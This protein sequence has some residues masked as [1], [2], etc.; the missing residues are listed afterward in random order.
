MSAQGDGVA[1]RPTRPLVF[2]RAL[3]GVGCRKQSARVGLG[4]LAEPGRLVDRLTDYGVFEALPGADVPG[5]DLPRGHADA[6]IEVGHFVGQP[7]RDTPRGGQG[8]VFGIIK[9]VGCPEDGQRRIALEFV[10]QSAVAV[11]LLDDDREETVQHRN[12]FGGGVD[13]SPAGSTRRCR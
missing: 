5:D 9:A 1:Q 13:S 4:E 12:D 3:D 11:H 10:D 6:G 8:R 7:P 2:V